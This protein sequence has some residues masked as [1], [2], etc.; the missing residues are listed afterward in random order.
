MSTIVHLANTPCVHCHSCLPFTSSSYWVSWVRDK[1][2][3]VRVLLYEPISKGS[4][5]GASVLTGMKRPVAHFEACRI[6][7]DDDT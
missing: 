5:K 7:D 2:C 4:C 6:D 1:V 3:W